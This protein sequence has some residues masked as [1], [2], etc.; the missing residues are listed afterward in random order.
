MIEASKSEIISE[1]LV[2]DRAL[3]VPEVAAI[4]R[5]HYQ[6]V[7]N[8]INT[9]RLRAVK[10]STRRKIVW[11]SDLKKYIDKINAE[12]NIFEESAIAKQE[13]L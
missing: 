13:S 11:E 2:N 6:T 12:S 5:V 8:L 9:G 4:L 10:V 3:R 7:W 1:R